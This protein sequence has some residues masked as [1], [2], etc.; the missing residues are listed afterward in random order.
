[1]Y[2]FFISEI[3]DQ[4][5]NDS[6]VKNNNTTQQDIQ[7]HNPNE[8]IDNTSTK[9]KREDKDNK[10][11]NDE[12]NIMILV[13]YSEEDLD[14]ESFTFQDFLNTYQ[15]SIDSDNTKTQLYEPYDNDENKSIDQTILYE[16]SEFKKDKIKIELNRSLNSS[17]EE[18]TQVYEPDDNLI[19]EI[20]NH[21]IISEE[22]T[23]KRN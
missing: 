21:E 13:E 23:K 8:N 22:K 19:T 1:L 7:N 9:N 10:V 18:S 5:S 11:S 16:P 2:F 17:Q 12:D 20:N 15:K 4:F 14:K 3:S 6:I